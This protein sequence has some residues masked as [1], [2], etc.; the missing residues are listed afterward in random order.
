MKFITYLIGEKTN[1]GILSANGELIADIN[2]LID[3]T[4]RDMNQLI[5][6]IS[7]SELALLKS[8]L[9]SDESAY[10]IPVDEVK[11]LAPIP[12]PKRPLFCLGKNYADHAKEVVGL[13]GADNSEAPKFPIFFMKIADPCLGDGDTIPN[14]AAITQ[15]IDYE[16]E[17]AVVIG[18]D[19]IDIKAEDADAHIFGY[20]I[21]NDVSARNIQRKHV[22]W[23][24]GKSLEGFAPLG[25]A[26]VHKSALQRPLNLNIRCMVN[27]ELRQNANTSNMIF[28]IPT[29]IEWLSKGMYLRKGDIILTGTPAGVVLGFDP[30]KFLRSG[31]YVSCS[32]SE[33]GTLNNRLE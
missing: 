23:F 1:I 25:P 18:K 6:E 29:I 28:D 30:Y 4:Y 3:T 17:L 24:K 32:I 22:Q 7:D 20:T 16:V 15:M 5:D 12:H 33:I 19:G 21:A 8:K 31:D 10:A 14:H 2:N 9:A 13:A 11:I 27:D 26:I